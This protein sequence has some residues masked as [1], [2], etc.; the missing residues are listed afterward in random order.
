MYYRFKVEFDWENGG[1]RLIK[2]AFRF[3]TETQNYADKMKNEWIKFILPLDEANVTKK[4][5]CRGWG[6]SAAGRRGRESWKNRSSFNLHSYGF[7]MVLFRGWSPWC[8]C[9]ECFTLI[10][11]LVVKT[12]RAVDP[13]C[14]F[15]FVPGT[16]SRLRYN[17]F[18]GSG[19]RGC[20]DMTSPPPSGSYIISNNSI[21]KS[22][23]SISQI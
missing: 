2:N 4:K 11:F 22:I 10:D 23:R 13:L 12:R 1:E 16:F 3:C 9:E 14:L 17:V 8:H 19:K 21:V 15:V 6:W 7:L 18:R 20:W 5:R